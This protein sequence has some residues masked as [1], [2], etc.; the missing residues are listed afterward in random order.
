L[1]S[2]VI[3]PVNAVTR[4]ISRRDHDLL[5]KIMIIERTGELHATSGGMRLRRSSVICSG[6]D[7]NFQS[8][9]TLVKWMKICPGTAFA[10]T[11]L[12]AAPEGFRS[13][14][15]LISLW[16]LGARIGIRTSSAVAAVV[17]PDSRRR[18]FG[19]GYG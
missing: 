9:Q 11:P 19:T 16:N 2:A 18:H 10:Q 7:K 12:R 14:V 3:G 15:D 13:A 1:L 17:V 6:E 5:I 4:R 8:E